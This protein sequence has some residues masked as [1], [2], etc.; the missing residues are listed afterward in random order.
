VNGAPRVSVIVPT[1]NGRTLLSEC[2]EALRASIGPSFEVIVVDDA[3]TD[4]TWEWLGRQT[5]PWLR[6]VRNSVNSGFARSMNAGFRA[7]RGQWLVALNNDTRVRPEFLAE[8]VRAAE[9]GFDMAAPRVLLQARPELDSAGI[10]PLRDGGSIERGRDRPVAAPEYLGPAEV[11]GPSASACLYSRRLIEAT[12]GFDEDFHAYF[13]DVDLAWR[14]RH[15][16]FR[17]TYWPAAIVEHHH[18]A[19]WGRLSD[20]K[21]FLLERNRLWTLWKNYPFQ[22]VAA[23]P[24]YRFV[25]AAS[26]ISGTSFGPEVEM[27]LKTMGMAHLGT[28]VLRADAA[29]WMGFGKMWRKRQQIL[30]S[31]KL[32]KREVARWLG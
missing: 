10:I 21:L 7:A 6:R 14:A 32:S 24:F 12:G 1:W 31:T 4:D 23:E 5:E 17:C 28:V 29:A 27:G 15:A 25:V 19:T 18:S 30:G 9:T 22:W 11:F 13:E 26:T 8:L 3:S 20:R 16:G 2:V